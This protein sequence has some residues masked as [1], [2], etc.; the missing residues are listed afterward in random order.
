[1]AGQFPILQRNRRVTVFWL[2]RMRMAART[3]V[4]RVLIR[5]RDFLSSAHMTDTEFIFS[6]LS[7]ARTVGP[8]R[9]TTSQGAGCCVRSIARQDGSYGAIRSATGQGPLAS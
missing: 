3:F 1:M 8:A 6:S 4:L 7:M 2:R 9:T 5:G